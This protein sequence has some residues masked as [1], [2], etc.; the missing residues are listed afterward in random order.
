MEVAFVMMHGGSEE[1]CV[2]G[3]TRKALEEFVEVNFLKTHPRLR[4]LNITE[5]EKA[6]SVGK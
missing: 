6:K 3:K 1:I 5:P 4:E 2:R